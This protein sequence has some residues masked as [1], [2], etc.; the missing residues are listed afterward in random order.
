MNH[1]RVQLVKMSEKQK[2]ISLRKKRGD[3]SKKNAPPVISAPRQ[4]SAPMPAGVAATAAASLPGSGRPSTDSNRSRTRTDAALPGQVRPQR[5]DKTADLVKRR[6]SQKVTALP[7]GFSGNGAPLPQLPQM[8]A[9]FRERSQTREVRPPGSSGDN[10]PRV[11]Q[12]DPRALRDPNL[13]VEQ[14]V[15]TILADASEADISRYQDELRKTKHRTS[16]DLQ[17]NVYQNRTQFIKIS[18]EAE[19]LKGEMRTLRQLMSDLTTTLEQTASATGATNDAASSRRANRSS[20]GDLNQLRAGQ[21]QQL[22]RDVEG[23]QKYLPP[24]PGRYIVWKST[25][26]FELDS[27]TLKARRRVRLL[28]LNDHLLIAVEKKA[29]NNVPAQQRDGSRPN[30]EFIAQRC[31][32]LQDTQ[33]TRTPEERIIIRA[34]SETYTYDTK[35]EDTGDKS[36]FVATFRKTKDDLRKSQEADVQEKDRTQHSY[37]HLLS[38]DPALMN[39]TELLD[40]LS[41]GINNEQVSTFV[42]IDGQQR[43]IRWVESQLDDLDIEIALQ[44][45]EE[46][47]VKVDRLKV[48]AKNIRGNEM[49]KT[50]VTYKVSER[51]AKLANVL[52][53]HMVEHNN[54]FT[55]VKQHTSWVVQLGFE[56]RAREA[57][58]EARSN[59]I[60]T[61]SRQCI[62]EGNLPDYIFQI[63]Y[64]Y[65]TIIKNTVDMFQKCFPQQLMSAC[66]K[67]AKE[68][69]DQFNILLKRQLSSVEEGGNVW[70]ECLTIA[71]EHAEML[72]GVGLDFTELVG[73]GISESHTE[74]GQ[75]PVG[76]GVSTVKMVSESENIQYL[77]VVLTNNGKP[78]VSSAPTSHQHYADIHKIDYEAVGTAMDLNKKAVCK[79]WSRLR[80]TLD[81]G[82]QPSPW[83]YQFLWLCVKHSTRDQPFNWAEI[84]SKCNTTSGAASKR[85]SRMKIEFE[86]GEAPPSSPAAKA[87]PAKLKATPK[88]RVKKNEIATDSDEDTADTQDTPVKAKAIPKVKAKKSKAGTAPIDDSDYEDAPPAVKRKRAVPKKTSASAAYETKYEVDTP[89]DEADVEDEADMP[90][91]RAKVDVSKLKPKPKPKMNSKA[92]LAV[93]EESA[94]AKEEST[95]VKK[96]STSV[97]E[98]SDPVKQELAP[99]HAYGGSKNAKISELRHKC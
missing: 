39:R 41:D 27:A 31:F 30:M 42:D 24:I 75:G 15:S 18:K 36:A 76:L 2:G 43:N 84:A 52:V 64:I 17:H 78:S 50:I 89:T 47:V 16:L 19:K 95:S 68:S 32:P 34:G 10:G 7:G 69:I 94:S 98:E 77:Y 97:K 79:R 49:A 26:W 6:Y 20:I 9:Q 96:E 70:N 62:F 63:S 90:N 88:S 99:E 74:A 55:S 46:A 81:K 44:H 37:S 28:L 65:F 33:V 87:T 48:L 57:Y 14:Y 71:H 40:N 85:F 59:L 29:R 86:G 82:E 11:L 73:N 93:K 72:R 45:F 3:K 58:L 91:K 22:Y 83:T 25:R 21:L 53:K 4:I 35:K 12:V 38:R 5:P 92:K 8:P 56:D 67:W 54:W 23:S 80:Q 1:T 66:V 51:A 61:R 13:K 60:K